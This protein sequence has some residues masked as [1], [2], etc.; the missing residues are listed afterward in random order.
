[1]EEVDRSRL[2]SV[3]VRALAIVSISVVSMVPMVAGEM[4]VEKAPNGGI[5]FSGCSLLLPA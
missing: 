2:A 4:P 3:V 5:S 1:M